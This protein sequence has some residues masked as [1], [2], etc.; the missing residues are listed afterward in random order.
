MIVIRYNV[1]GLPASVHVDVSGVKLQ[2]QQ[3]NAI[4]SGRLAVGPRQIDYISKT[5]PRTPRV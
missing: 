2:V 5:R 4:A 3:E 1:P